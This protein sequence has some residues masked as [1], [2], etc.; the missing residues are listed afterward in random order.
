M[1]KTAIIIPSRISAQKIPNKPL[2]L[3]NNKEMIFTV[4]DRAKKSALIKFT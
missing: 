4:F 1:I 2:K 3:I